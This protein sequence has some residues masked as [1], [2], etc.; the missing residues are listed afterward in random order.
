MQDKLKEDYKKFAKKVANKLREKDFWIKQYNSY[1]EKMLKNEEKYKDYKKIFREWSPFH[2]YL[3]I[4]YTEKGARKFDLRYLGQSVGIISID[5]DKAYLTVKNDRNF[6]RVDTNKKYFGY[7]LGEINKADW[8]NDEKAKQFRKFYRE[9]K[10]AKNIDEKHNSPK[11]EEHMVESALFSELGKT[12][13]AQNKKLCNITPVSFA[14]IRIHMKTALSASK[15]KNGEFELSRN[16][17]EIDLFCRRRIGN[18]SRLVVI[19]IK[20]QNISSESFDNAMKQAI[21]YS[22]FISELL[23]S[24]QKACE[25]WM[26]LWGMSNQIHQKSFIIDCVVAMPKEGATAPSYDG[27]EIEL[28]NGDKLKLHYIKITSEINRLN[29]DDVEFETSLDKKN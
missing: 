9:H 4:G 10:K 19:E 24:G 18:R 7:N 1:A 15:A 26:K 27:D 22:V 5:K 23:H 14:G 16:G 29:S 12:A 3:T 20:D 17:G 28:D 25:R 8:R 2:L 6:K 13:K 21:A 11:S